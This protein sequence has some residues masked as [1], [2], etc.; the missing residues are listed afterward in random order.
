MLK[1]VSHPSH[2]SYY[3]SCSLLHK[4][5]KGGSLNKTKRGFCIKTFKSRELVCISYRGDPSSFYTTILV[6]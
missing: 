3:S 4:V 5:T 6:N 2:P 1:S